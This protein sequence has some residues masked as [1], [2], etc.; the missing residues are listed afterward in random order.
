MLPFPQGLH[1]NI[2][3]LVLIWLFTIALANGGVYR[4]Q[5]AYVGSTFFEMFNFLEHPDPLGGYVRYL[6]RRSARE[7]GLVKASSDRVKI[8][9]DMSSGT[10]TPVGSVRLTSKAVFNSGLFVVSLDHVPSGCGS[11]PSLWMSGA[12][13]GYKLDIV[14]GVHTSTRVTT[15]LH[16]ATR[17]DQSS[18]QG[19]RDLTGKWAK[20]NSTPLANDCNDAAPGQWKNQ[21]CEQIGPRDSMGLPFNLQGG[22]TF[23]TE[24]EPARGHISTWFFRSGTLPL[25]LADGKALVD[26]RS[27]GR[28][29]S[30][31][32]FSEDSCPASVLGNVSIVLDLNLCGS[33]GD[34]LFQSSCP[35]EAAIEPKCSDFL[36][37]YPEVLSE[38]YWSIRRLDVYE[39][40][41]A[42]EIKPAAKASDMPHNG[43]GG[44]QAIES[45]V[46]AGML[47]FVQNVVE[48]SKEAAALAS[49]SSNAKQQ[50][51]V[52]LR[53]RWPMRN[54]AISGVSVTLVGL[55]LGVAAGLLWSR[56]GSRTR[57]RP[58]ALEE[59]HLTR[60]DEQAL[61]GLGGGGL[62]ASGTVADWSSC[63]QAPERSGG[64]RSLARLWEAHGIK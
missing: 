52:S 18:I 54:M 33:Y 64:I 3:Y 48:G 57:L 35:H 19:N 4:K 42:G 2:G 32:H 46:L 8:G 55:T 34:A 40:I 63:Q 10:A 41:S 30:L 45:P 61:P 38:A 58:Q 13:Q 37:K 49:S 59:D 1:M 15:T 60:E 11:W 29:Y 27:W 23:V 47:R 36:V 5:H 51:V 16:T 17:C 25:D 24:W 7:A 9:V 56:R 22:G 50:G 28:P 62:V 43:S 20:G 31:F 44:T 6:D 53:G 14:E 12:Q 39:R 26:T 21:G